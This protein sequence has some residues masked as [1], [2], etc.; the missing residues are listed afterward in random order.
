MA[1]N[2]L[3]LNQIVT[4]DSLVGPSWSLALEFW[5]YCLT[6]F[7]F[8]LHPRTLRRLIFISFAAFLVYTCGRTVFHWKYFAG[9][10]YGLNV[11]L[12]SFVWLAGLRLARDKAD[13][14]RTLNEVALMFG[15]HIA[16]TFGIQLGIR[17][18]EGYVN[19]VTA[20]VTG[21]V[22]ILILATVVLAPISFSA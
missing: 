3:F 22:V 9:V 12:L 13:A 2:A 1:I 8:K 7:L 20:S 15:A 18:K 5:L 14:P 4:S 17:R 21:A 19:R 6:P 11:L 10:G 16:L